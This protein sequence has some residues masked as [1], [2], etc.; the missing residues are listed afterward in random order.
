VEGC[1]PRRWLC[2]AAMCSELLFVAAGLDFLQAFA[3]LAPVV[4]YAQDGFGVELIAL[5]DL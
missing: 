4:G 3:V 1:L 5:Q 2:V